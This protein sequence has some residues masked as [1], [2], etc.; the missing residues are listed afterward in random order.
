MITAI[1]FVLI[2]LSFVVIGLASGRK[3]TGK[4]KDYYL[5]SS[6]VSPWLAG[7]SAVATNNSGYMFIG[8]IGFT[9]Q[10]GLA[11]MWLMIGW[12]VGD[13]IGSSFIHKRLR[14]ATAKTGEASFAGVIARWYGEKFGIWQKIAGVIMIVFLIAYAAAQISAGGKAL[15][16]V[17]GINPWTGAVMVAAMV[18][19]YSIVGGIRASIWTDG[20]QSITMMFAMTILLI[21]AFAGVGGV[22][23]ALELWSAIPGFLDP[24]PDDLLFP[25]ALGMG[26]FIVGWLF[27]GFSVVGQPHVMVRFMALDHD[28]NMGRARAWYYGYFTIFYLLATGV[29]ML[30]RLY[31]PD[32]ADIDPELALPMMATELLPPVLVGVILAGI[33]AATMS[34]ADSL[35]LS[36]SASF[37]H[38]LAPERLETPLILKTATAVSILIALGLA[39]SGNQS[40]FSLVILAWSTLAAAFAP[41]LTLYALRRR[42]SEPVAIMM[43]V[44]GVSIALFWRFGLGWHESI[45]EGLPG[46]LVPLI[47]GWFLSERREIAASPEPAAETSPSA[48]E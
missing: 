8:V 18:L 20:A 42:V 35:V 5:A 27:A 24:F 16:G 34:T 29:G 7:L 48:A 41:L 45:Y 25:G 12:I 39:L 43:L 26:L 9:Y 2:L 38:D 17:L 21:A 19:L 44:L 47:I 40:V 10:T 11:A 22:S 6:S 23:G 32:L 3:A 33:F 30:S 4:R 46:I 15:E 1:S 31:L 37:T 13:F 28:R 36:C 14:Q